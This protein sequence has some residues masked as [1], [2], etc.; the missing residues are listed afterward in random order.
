MA[1]EGVPVQYVRDE[2]LPEFFRNFWVR[3]MASIDATTNSWVRTVVVCVSYVACPDIIYM[4]LCMCVRVG[5]QWRR[6]LSWP[7][8]SVP[9]PLSAAP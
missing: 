2:I 3:R 5:V 8:R 1:T 9:V 4:S 6:P 7:T